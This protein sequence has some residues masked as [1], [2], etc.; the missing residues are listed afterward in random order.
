MID[1]G[2]LTMKNYGLRRNCTTSIISPEKI[3]LLSVDVGVTSASSV[4]EAEIGLSNQVCGI[5]IYQM[6]FYKKKRNQF[7]LTAMH[8]LALVNTIESL[9]FKTA[10]LNMQILI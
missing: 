6:F 1:M 8:L 2:V 5:R 4:L 9:F 3:H 7:K 10:W